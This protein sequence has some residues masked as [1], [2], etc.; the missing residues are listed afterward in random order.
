MSVQDSPDMRVGII[1]PAFQ[2]QASIDAVVRGLK[3][4]WP[5]AG[6]VLV[7][8]DGST[9]E[10]GPRARAAGALVLRHPE[11]RG[12]G[13]ALRTGL[14]DLAARKFDVALSVDADGQ[15][16]PDEAKLLHIGCDDPD[17]MVIG[18]RDLADAGAP[19]D[20]QWSNAFSNRVLS[21]FTGQQLD[22]T[23]SGLRR[24]PITKTLALRGRAR[25]YAYE[26]EVLI[27]AI[28]ADIR[29]VHLPIDV[30]Y[31]PEDERVSHFHHVRDPARIVVRVVG[32]V[33]EERCRK[34]FG[35]RKTKHSP[36]GT[37]HEPD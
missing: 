27:R 26:A 3:A 10:T 16:P 24:Y 13:E 18:V 33:L 22:D 19:R 29:I 14:Q 6:A 9:D 35:R 11:N 21:A 15:H 12:K 7:V 28:A 36:S 23:Q 4:H 1:V 32:T 37:A 25:G 30:I 5:E 8:D 34:L 2:A 17:A 31:P 20:S